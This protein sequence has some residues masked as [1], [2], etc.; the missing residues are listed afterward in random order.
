MHKNTPGP[1]LPGVKNVC[2]QLETSSAA[3]T[4]NSRRPPAA[5]FAPP[6]AV[7]CSIGT[8]V[9][10][11]VNLGEKRQ[12]GTECADS[13]TVCTDSCTARINSCIMC[14]DSCT[15]R[16]DSSTACTDSCS[17]CTGSCTMCTDS[18]TACIT[19][20]TLCTDSYTLCTASCT[21]CTDCGPNGREWDR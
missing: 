20:C 21:V 15:A 5:H 14:A 8:Q 2:L 7:T 11:R 16:R 3:F 12:C 9:K 13:C 18:C 10:G 6:R 19:S 17:L 4:A 1:K